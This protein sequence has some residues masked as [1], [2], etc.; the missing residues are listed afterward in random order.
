MRTAEHRVRETPVTL[1]IHRYRRVCNV[2]QYHIV[3]IIPIRKKNYFFSAV[4]TAFN[5]LIILSITFNITLYFDNRTTTLL[6]HHNH[7]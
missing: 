2:V 3:I 5:T 1:L 6:P 4:F 7:H